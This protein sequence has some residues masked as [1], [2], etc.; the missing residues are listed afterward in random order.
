MTPS[1]LRAWNRPIHPGLPLSTSADSVGTLG[2]IVRDRSDGTV[3]VLGT[4]HVLCAGG[5]C[6]ATVWQPGPCNQKG[7][8]CNRVG[9]AVRARCGVV[10]SGGH[11]YFVDCAI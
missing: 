1:P 10:V 7:C 3:F 8:V 2:A 9:V 6:D 4:S 5:S 11:R